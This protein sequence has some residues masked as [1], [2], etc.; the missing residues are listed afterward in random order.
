MNKNQ[1]LL[2]NNHCLAVCLLE[3]VLRR[4]LPVKSFLLLGLRLYFLLILVVVIIRVKSALLTGYISN[5]LSHKEIQLIVGTKQRAVLEIRCAHRDVNVII[6]VAAR[7]PVYDEESHMLLD[8]RLKH[9]IHYTK[10]SPLVW[11]RIS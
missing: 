7:L 11:S 10:S 9:F 6:G 2:V 1:V 8:K 4:K 5:T 3:F